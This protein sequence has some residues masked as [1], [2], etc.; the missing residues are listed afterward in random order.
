MAILPKVENFGIESKET[1]I[2]TLYTCEHAITII[3][4]ISNQNTSRKKLGICFTEKNF[5]KGENAISRAKSSGE[6]REDERILQRKRH[7]HIHGMTC[8]K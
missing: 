6:L 3:R 4:Y 2:A 8:F 7:K 1:K 5:G